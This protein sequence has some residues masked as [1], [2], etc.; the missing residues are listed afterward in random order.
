[1]SD[2]Q[3][4]KGTYDVMRSPNIQTLSMV[5]K[6]LRAALRRSINLGKR[7]DNTEARTDENMCVTGLV[8]LIDSND[9]IDKK[10]PNSPVTKLPTMKTL[11]SFPP[12]VNK[13][14]AAES[15]P[16]KTIPGIKATADNK[17]PQ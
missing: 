1:M 8:T 6:T 15:S 4:V 7:S 5:C 10:N 11:L 16:L 9:A 14:R 12:V 17:L 13:Y 2:I 3:G